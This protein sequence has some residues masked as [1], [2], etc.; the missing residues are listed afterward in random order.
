MNPRSL[1]HTIAFSA[2]L[3]GANPVGAAA[4]SVSASGLTVSVTMTL[5]QQQKVVLQFAV[6]NDLSSRVYLRDA[7]GDESQRA[8]L[9]SGQQLFAPIMSGLDGC[10]SMFAVQ[11]ITQLAA[12]Q[13][14]NRYSYIEPGKFISFSF[15]YQ[16]SAPVS[17]SDTISFQIALV[18]RFASPGHDPTQPG[19][20]QVIP[21][22]FNDVP[23]NHH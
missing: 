17:E 15:T 21:F 5:V 11:C 2:M 18:G 4:Q 19:Q 22:P 13:D 7:D 10:A 23:L 3:C 6:A 20:P 9:G 12:A 8:R 14:I 16:A 1:V